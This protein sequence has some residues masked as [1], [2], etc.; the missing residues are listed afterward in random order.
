[1]ELFMGSSAR[2]HE[3]GV[4]GVGKAVGAGA[5]PGHDGAFLEDKDGAT[6]AGQRKDVGDCLH[7]FR[8]CN[9]MSF[10]VENAEAATLFS[11]EACDEGRAVGADAPDLE[12]R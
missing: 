6:R 12:V 10:A 7:P 11:R 1:M 4:V 9:S 3:I 8:I 2:P 5:S